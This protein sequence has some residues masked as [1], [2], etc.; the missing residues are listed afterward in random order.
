MGASALK[1]VLGPRWTVRARCV[2]RGKP[3]PR[4]GNLRRTRPLSEHFG[5]D[6]GTP[7]DRYYLDRFL[8]SH[9]ERVTGRVLEIQ[10][11][12]STERYG[13]SVTA[14][15]TIDINPSFN[16]TFLCDL[17]EADRVVPADWYD[18]VLLPNTLH[19]LRDVP[20]S[21]VQMLRV[22]KPG[23][24]LLATA[25]GFVPLIPDGPDYWRLSEQ[26]WRELTAEPLRGHRFEL[27]AYGN[28]LAAVSALLGVTVEELTPAELDVRDARYPVLVTLF[29]TRANG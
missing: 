14:A 20:R 27:D 1:A 7:I 22:L 17:A 26:G 9:R 23:G 16:P 24:S 29:C 25:C 5:A 8:T 4:W 13:Q 21:L 3:L 12:S 11:S 28:C 15:D 19:H 18:C 2:L 6:R 10:G